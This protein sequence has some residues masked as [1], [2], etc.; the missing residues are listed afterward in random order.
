MLL[1]A[2]FVSVRTVPNKEDPNN[3]AKDRTY[4]TIEGLNGKLTSDT[5]Y[6][7]GAL[8]GLGYSYNE[9][10]VGE[11][12]LPFAKALW[13]AM[14]HAGGLPIVC[15]VDVAPFERT[16]WVDGK[17]AGREKDVQIED[18]EI[19]GVF[20]TEYLFNP[21]ASGKVQKLAPRPQ[22]P[23]NGARGGAPK[24]TAPATI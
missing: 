3:R 16:N 12:A 4:A 1:V 11:A 5:D 9:L 21:Q 8:T 13:D 17:P 7:T 18:G 19:L 22:P 23:V 2:T 15:N 6:K 24:E 20:G 14:Q 10:R